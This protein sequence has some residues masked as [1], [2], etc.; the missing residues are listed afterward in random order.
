ME[1]TRETKAPAAEPA[2]PELVAPRDQPVQLSAD[3]IALDL[4]RLVDDG[5]LVPADKAL[6]LWLVADARA[7]KLSYADIGRAIGYDASTVSKILRAR[8]EGNWRNVLKSVRAYKHLVDERGKMLRPDFIETSVWTQIRDTCDLALVHE[9]PATIV[10]VSQIGKTHALLEYQ[11]RSEYMVRYVR[12]P[13]APGLRCAME[14]VADACNVTT[15]CTSEQL[16]RRVADSLDSRSLLIVD[17]FHQLAISAGRESSIKIAEWIREIRDR[18]GCGL[19]LCGTKALRHDLIDGPLKGWLEQL[20][21]RAIRNLVLPDRLPFSDIEL[22]GRTYGLPAPRG[23]ILDL[24]RTLRM[25]RL[26]KVLM[27]AATNARKREVPL[28]WDMFL[29][30]YN[31]VNS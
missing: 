29:Q 27:L 4:D 1:A 10:G 13:A 21:E 23:Q 11:R 31:T 28:T 30:T 15:R 24:L 16:R 5:V 6:L 20:R 3:G 7:R 2:A 12:M 17:E 9:M 25:N 19:V 18:S 22:V 14:A 26:C 8:Y